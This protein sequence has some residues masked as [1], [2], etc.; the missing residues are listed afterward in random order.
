MSTISFLIKQ[1][2]ESLIEKDELK[3]P[4]LP[5]IIIDARDV[6]QNPKRSGADLAKVIGQDSAIAAKIIKAANNPAVRVNYLVT[7]IASAV[8]RLGVDIACNLTVGLAM[9]QVFQAASKVID[10]KMKAI[11]AQN[12]QIAGIAEKITR[13]HTKLRP[14]VASLGGL[15]HTIG[16]LPILTYLDEK[17][18]DLSDE[19]AIEEIIAEIHPLLGVK[20]LSVWDFPEQLVFI[21]GQYLNL[22]RNSATIDLC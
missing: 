20:I 17:V 12:I 6:A 21:P 1:D 14:D 15:V 9:S 4:S 19:I 13:L 7:D 18:V 10:K 16:I 11:W 22:E 2:L 5:E 3:L 8:N